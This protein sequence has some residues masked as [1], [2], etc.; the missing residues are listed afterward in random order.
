MLFALSPAI[1]I[2]LPVAA[3]SGLVPITDGV[4][5]FI[6]LMVLLVL[7]GVGLLLLL[8]VSRETAPYRRITEV[9]SPPTPQSHVG[10]SR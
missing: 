7:A 4:G 3:E 1:L 10:P 6:G 8:A 9:R 5:V 2:V